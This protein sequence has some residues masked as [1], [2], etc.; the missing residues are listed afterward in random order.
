ME[1]IHYP[2][3]CHRRIEPERF[4]T[5]GVEV[6][7]S[8]QLIVLPVFTGTWTKITYFPAQMF[9]LRWMRSE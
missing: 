7:E 4:A 1:N 3:P 9:L 2:E 6:V 8:I 5:Y